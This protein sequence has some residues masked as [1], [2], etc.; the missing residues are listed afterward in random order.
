MS[1]KA[2]EFYRNA[3]IFSFFIIDFGS[4]QGSVAAQQHVLSARKQVISCFGALINYL[5]EFGLSSCLS[6]SSN[7]SE[8]TQQGV[9]V[10]LYV[11]LYVCMYVCM[12][13][14]MCMY[15]CMHVCMLYVYM[16]VCICVY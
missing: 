9:R 11:C 10:C 4:T 13:A 12:Y 3:C 15:V 1:I 2:R 6:V 7:I 16:I 14:F 8:F 5:T